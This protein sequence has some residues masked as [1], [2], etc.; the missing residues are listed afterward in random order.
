MDSETI[1]LTASSG[2]VGAGLTILGNYILAKSRQ[3]REI[4]PQPLLVSHAT[5]FARQSDLIDLR[6]QNRD[7]HDEIENRLRTIETTVHTQYGE[8]QRLLGILTGKIE[9]ILDR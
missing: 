6:Q 4:T 1:T 2:I 5:E 7:E 3:R 8:I 9:A